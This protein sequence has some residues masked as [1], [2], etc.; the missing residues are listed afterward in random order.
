[1]KKILLISSLLLSVISV[2][3]FA[4]EKIV[5]MDPDLVLSRSNVVQ[6]R[7]KAFN[8]QE[9]FKSL[10]ARVNSLQEELKKLQQEQEVNALVWSDEQKLSHRNTMQAKVDERNLLAN[11]IESERSRV[12]SQ[13]RRELTPVLEKVVTELVEKNGYEL[14]LHQR[15]IIFSTEQNTI[16]QLVIDA[17]NAETAKNEAQ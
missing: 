5:V 13:A 2:S 9:E 11:Q 14:I 10:L 12:L 3:V 8:E 1:M 7:L 6:N 17:L 15:V 16:T 4:Q